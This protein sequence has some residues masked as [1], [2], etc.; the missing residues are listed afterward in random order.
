MADLS[1]LD[2]IASDDGAAYYDRPRRG[3]WLSALVG[4]L[5]VVLIA[6]WCAINGGC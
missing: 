5:G 4:V 3:P 1:D 6:A 2:H